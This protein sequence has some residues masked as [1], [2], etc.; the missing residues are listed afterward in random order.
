MRVLERIT[1][2]QG[3]DVALQIE[4]LRDERALG[5]AGTKGEPN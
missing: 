1:T 3:V 2:D 5:I 4:S